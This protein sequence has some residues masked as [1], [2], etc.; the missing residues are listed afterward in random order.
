[1]DS[2]SKLDLASLSPEDRKARVTELLTAM[3]DTPAGAEPEPTANERRSR[4][5]LYM[6]LIFI[7][8]IFG[9]VLLLASSI[10]FHLIPAPLTYITTQ[11]G[12]IIDLTPLKK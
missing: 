3:S 11:D 12:R 8:T 6:N 5:K 7:A 9:S 2:S 1:M 10:Y 4:F